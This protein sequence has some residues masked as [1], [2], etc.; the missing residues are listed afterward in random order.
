M[1]LY[2]KKIY[3]YIYNYTSLDDK[4]CKSIRTYLK[5]KYTI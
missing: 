2:Y 5:T 3:I 4:I 1:K